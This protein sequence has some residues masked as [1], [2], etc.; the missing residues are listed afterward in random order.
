MINFFKYRY[1]TDF[2]CFFVGI[3]SVLVAI[4]LLSWL[5]TFSVITILNTILVIV[6]I[7]VCMGYKHGDSDQIKDERKET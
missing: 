6:L 1:W 7:I 4:N 2:E 5:A 3:F